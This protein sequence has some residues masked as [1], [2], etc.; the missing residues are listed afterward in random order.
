MYDDAAVIA[1]EAEKLAEDGKD[2]VIIAHSY[3]G[4]P[5]SQSTKGL[6]KQDRKSQGEPGG[7]VRLAYI[8]SIVPAKGKSSQDV[9]AVR[10]AEQAPPMALDVSFSECE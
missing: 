9:L 5:A 10:P 2:V 1:S 7:V 6:E 8:A 3:G 4:I